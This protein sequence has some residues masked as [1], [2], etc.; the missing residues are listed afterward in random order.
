MKNVALITGNRFWHEGDGGSTRTY[1]LC[2]YLSLHTRL[3]IIYVGD[4]ADGADLERIG[5]VSTAFAL[6]PRKKGVE[7][8]D[9]F[10][11]VGRYLAEGNFAACIVDRLHNAWALSLIPQ[12]TLSILDT[13]DLISHYDST[14]QRYG[15]RPAYGHVRLSLEKEIRLFAKFDIVMLIQWRE[16]ELV[17]GLLGKDRCVIAP[18]PVVLDRHELRPTV[19]HIGLAASD[20]ITN[21][22]GLNWFAS[23]VWPRVRRDGITLDIY[24]RVC[25]ALPRGSIPGCVLHGFV[26]HVAAAY[27]QIDIVINP[28]RAGSGLKIKNVEALA[29]GLPLVTTPAGASGLE[30]LAGEGLLVAETASG[31]A[32]HLQRLIESPS[33]RQQLGRGAYAFAASHLTPE[34]CFG[35]LVQIIET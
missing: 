27:N 13:H 4:P 14:T 7:S 10:D 28:V 15:L 25:D 6:V 3:T 21:V 20:W 22:D 5:A 12:E 29:R 8:Q 32:D 35:R 33:L 26:D 23:E 2:R 30:E 17:S 18:H 11:A 24:G 31:Y 16:Y 1:S 9:I 34:A 19:H